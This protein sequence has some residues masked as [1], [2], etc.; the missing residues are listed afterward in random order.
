MADTARIIEIVSAD[1]YLA[2][3]R[4]TTHRHEFVNG[5]VYAMSGGSLRHNIIAVN[6]TTALTAHLP[7]RCVAYMADTKLRIRME[8]AEFF[9]YPDSMVCCGP[10][11]QSLDWRDNPLVLGEVLSPSTV[12]VDR[13]EKFDAYRQIET[14]QEYVLIEQDAVRVEVFRRANAWQREVLAAAD[15]LRL[16]SIGFEVPVSALY[17]RVEF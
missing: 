1:A 6:L 9:Y 16:P 3:E 13:G 4:A 2:R 7:E 10:S 8:R 11:D 14:L 17:R 15:A 5:S 12:R